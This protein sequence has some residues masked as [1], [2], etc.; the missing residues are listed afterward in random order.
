MSRLI[1]ADAL[2]AKLEDDAKYMEEPIAKMF[3]YAAVN[4]IKHAPTISPD[5]H[6]IPC[7]ERLPEKKGVYLTTTMYGDVFCGYWNELNFDRTEM[8]IA[9]MPLPEP[10]MRGEQDD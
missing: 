6:W 8:V 2:I 1:D 10:Y 9:W 7:S 3:T 4:D 5:L